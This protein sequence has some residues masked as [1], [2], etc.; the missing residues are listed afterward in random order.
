MGGGRRH[1]SVDSEKE[2]EEKEHWIFPSMALKSNPFRLVNERLRT[3]ISCMPK[4]ELTYDVTSVGLSPFPFNGIYSLTSLR[5]GAVSHILNHEALRGPMHGVC[6]LGHDRSNICSV[7]EYFWMSYASQCQA[8]R[9]LA[10]WASHAVK[11]GQ[12]PSPNLRTIMDNE[13]KTKSANYN[14]TI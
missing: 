11:H 14:C 1:M 5:D 7:F 13:K 8:G 6:R 12:I 10:G 2:F 3:A 4:A 9:A